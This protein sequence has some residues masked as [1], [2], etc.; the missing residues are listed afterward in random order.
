MSELIAELKAEHSD[1]INTLMRVKM[2]GVRSKDG[3]RI[4]LSAKGKLLE[5]LKKE[6]EQLYPALKS[7]A[8]KNRALRHQLDVLSEDMEEVSRLALNFF[9]KY[10]GGIPD[11]GD[12]ASPS[13]F[14]RIRKLLGKRNS[15][16][17]EF[18]RDFE[19]LY[20]ALLERIQKEGSILYTAFEKLNRRSA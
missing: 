5:H 12:N 2:L 8:E 16:E 14:E 13:F 18:S 20:R 15:F 1:I 10:S 9:E 19:T 6:D 17:S 7:A 3:Q 11:D 4:L